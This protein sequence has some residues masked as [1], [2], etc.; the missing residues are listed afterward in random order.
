MAAPRKPNILLIVADDLGYGDLGCYGAKVT[1][2]PHLDD[3]AR[4]GVRFTDFHANGPVC[5]PTRCALLTGQYQ[6]RLGIV[7]ALGEHDPGLTVGVPT[8]ANCLAGEGYA[9]G[10][11]G[12]WHL[13]LDMRYCPLKHGFQLFHGHRHGAIDYVSHITKYGGHDWWHNEEPRDEQGYCTQL[14]TDHSEAFIRAHAHQP[15]FMFVAHSAIH[16]PWMAPGD[17]AHRRRGVRYDGLDRLGPH[18]PEAVGRVVQR[19]IEALD[20]SVGRMV[21]VLR[22]LDL[23]RDTLIVFLSDNGGIVEM[24]GGYTQISSNGELRNQKGSLYEGGHRV[25]ALAC[26]PG[27]IAPGRTET[28]PAATMDLMPTF[29][30]LAGAGLPTDACVDG[31]DLSDLLLRGADLPRRPLFWASGTQGAVRDG[32]WKLFTLGDQAEL[33][34]LDDDVREARNLAD[35]H[36]GEV[37]RLGALLARWRKDVGLPTS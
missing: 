21:A 27:R 28:R 16:F 26:W 14:I 37:N 20:E 5:S 29:L 25:P 33:Y 7:G 10:L 6:Q 24:A 17:P 13:G 19:M 1:H 31:V 30:R 22:E 12:K 8:I 2:T 9:S 23:E 3:L 15:F 35:Q 18:G 36:P 34:R 11:V 4:R 32:A